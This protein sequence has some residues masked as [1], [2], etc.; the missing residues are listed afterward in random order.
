MTEL[1]YSSL[2]D[3]AS[4]IKSR[5]VSPVE[6]TR[7]MLDRIAEIDPSYH[8]YL[9]VTPEAALEAAGIAE[10]EIMSG[11][12]RGRCTAFRSGSRT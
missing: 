2:V 4:M 3:L 12:Y 11:R 8:S 7:M 10:A 5:K 6:V 9:L 1:Y